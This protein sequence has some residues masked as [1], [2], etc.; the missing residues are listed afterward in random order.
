MK[1]AGAGEGEAHGWSAKTAG[2]E[3]PH[4]GTSTGVTLGVDWISTL[5]CTKVPETDV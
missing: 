1:T 3:A 5:Y 2:Q 4:P